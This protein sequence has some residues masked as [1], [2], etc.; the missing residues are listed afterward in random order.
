MEYCAIL[1]LHIST[2]CAALS[3]CAHMQRLLLMG[4]R[5]EALDVALAGQ[6]W[7][8]ALVL[9]HGYGKPVVQHRLHADGLPL[10]VC[11]PVHVSNKPYA[12]LHCVHCGLL[13]NGWQSLSFVGC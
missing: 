4:R 7:G 12:H 9:A 3:D 5:H 10:F 13:A 11:L 8:P 2:E 1:V 6:L